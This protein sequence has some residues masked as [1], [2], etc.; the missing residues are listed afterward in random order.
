[1]GLVIAC[2]RIA[3]D[4]WANEQAFQE[5]SALGPG[6]IW[7]LPEPPQIPSHGSVTT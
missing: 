6:P 7:T 5:A 1:V 3:H 2:Y 4:G